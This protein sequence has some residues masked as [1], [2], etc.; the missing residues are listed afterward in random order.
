VSPS[1]VLLSAKPVA[2]LT[3][4]PITLLVTV[5]ECSLTTVRCVAATGADLVAAYNSRMQQKTAG[6]ITV[7]PQ[8]REELADVI[9]LSR[10][11]AA[12]PQPK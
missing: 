2:M 3:A 8:R 12:R 4:V 7:A 11:R 10:E 6:T 1:S 9:P 5:W